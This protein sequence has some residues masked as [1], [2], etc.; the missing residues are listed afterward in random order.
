MHTHEHTSVHTCDYSHIHKYMQ[1]MCTHRTI[2][3]HKRKIDSTYMFRVFF[4]I[5]VTRCSGRSNL[6]EKGFILANSGKYRGKSRN[7][8]LEATGHMHPWSRSRE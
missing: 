8:D 1:H 3:I 7:E 5:A 6:K 4:S 2:D